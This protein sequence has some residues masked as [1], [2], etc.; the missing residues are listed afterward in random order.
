MKTYAFIQNG[1]IVEIIPPVE[2]P[3][4]KEIDI[5]DRFAAHFVSMMVNITDTPP[6]TRLALEVFRR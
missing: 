1:E 3:D 5:S 2:G 6:S 4:G